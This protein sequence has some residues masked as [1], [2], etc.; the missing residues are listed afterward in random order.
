M[1]KPMSWEQQT[2]AAV[3]RLE[4][5]GNFMDFDIAN[6]VFGVAHG[7]ALEAVELTKLRTIIEDPKKFLPGEGSKKK[8]FPDHQDGLRVR[9]M[10]LIPVN[11]YFAARPIVR[12]PKDQNAWDTVTTLGRGPAK[13]AGFVKMTAETPVGK[14]FEDFHARAAGAQRASVVRIV[15]AVRCRAMKPEDAYGIVNAELERLSEQKGLRLEAVD[16]G[17]RRIADAERLIYEALED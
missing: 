1:T 3:K 5:H 17:L 14:Y 8:I 15:E 9:A 11:A 2:R 6:D 16:E 13:T 10:K 7:L 12:N 4:M